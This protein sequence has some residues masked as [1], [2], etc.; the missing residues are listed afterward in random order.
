MIVKWSI[1]AT[2]GTPMLVR[3]L[4]VRLVV[5]PRLTF[6]LPTDCV[7]P[8]K[9]FALQL[10]PLKSCMSHARAEPQPASQPHCDPKLSWRE[11]P[12]G[13]GSY[14][15]WQCALTAAWPKQ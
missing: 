5:V 11:T 6:I 15:L 13:E 2:T 4:N 1:G 8:E 7:I 10:L 9:P 3:K 12:W 14:G